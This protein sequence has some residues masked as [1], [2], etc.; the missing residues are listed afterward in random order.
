MFIRSVGG[1]FHWPA[2]QAST[3]LMVPKEQLTRV[4]GMNQTLHGL[5]NVFGAPLGALLMEVLPLH[6]VMMVDVGTAA[7]A[8]TPLFFV[9]IPQPER[10]RTEQRHWF[11][12]VGVFQ[13]AAHRILK[14]PHS[15]NPVSRIPNATAGTCLVVKCDRTKL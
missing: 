9:H 14:M 4:A 7:L 8:V 15:D 1:S 2:M 6:G 10:L 5:L 3:S 12:W 13:A 11:R